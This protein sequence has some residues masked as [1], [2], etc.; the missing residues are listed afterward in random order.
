VETVG[1]DGTSN[2][3]YAGCGDVWL[4]QGSRKRGRSPLFGNTRA[5]L[6]LAFISGLKL[7][8]G[9]SQE[10]AEVARTLRVLS[11]LW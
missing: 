9:F 8:S 1:P 7:R 4:R 2:A 10:A 6:T 3:R 11:A 5:R